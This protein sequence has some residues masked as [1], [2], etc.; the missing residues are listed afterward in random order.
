[1]SPDEERSIRLRWLLRTAIGVIVLA[2]IL[3]IAS[4]SSRWIEAWV[5]LISLLVVG[6][7][8]ERIVSPGLLR[9]RMTRRH[10]DQM[11]WDRRLFV[12]YGTLTGFAL[13]LIAAFDVRYQW[14]PFLPWWI[15]GA[16]FLAFV[17]GWILNL[18]SMRVNPFF[19]QVVR[20]QEERGQRVIKAGPYRWVRHPGYLGGM[21]VT[22]GTPLV[23]GSFWA[24][25]V[26]IVATGLLLMRTALED[27]T[28]H[29]ELEGYES[30]SESV[31][32]R[33]VPYLW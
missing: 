29:L 24:W 28:L 1:M 31:R 10:P 6:V 14:G 23:L 12:V 25:T 3:F 4:G 5:Y 13:P 15:K 27:R 19:S 21:G 33:L 30:Y 16:A 11:A 8:T 20:L 2:A 18:W 32:Y 17:A 9:E 7:V 22:L 26:S